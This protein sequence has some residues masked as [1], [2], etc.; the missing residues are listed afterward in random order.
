VFT[1][2]YT[3]PLDPNDPTQVNMERRYP[4]VK[5]RKLMSSGEPFAKVDLLL[6]GD[7]YTEKEME[8]FENDV[9]HFT[10]VLFDTEPFKT[11]KIDFNVWTI[12][13][14]SV[15]S[16]IDKPD[17][18]VW[19]STPL[20]T[21]YNTFGSARYVLTEE[22][23]ALRDICSAV[24]Y[25]AIYILVNDNRY[26]GGGIYN[27][28][29]TC[30]TVTDAKGREWQ[31]DYV[32]VHEF[33]HSFAALADEYYSSDVAYNDMY[34]AGVEPWEPNITRYYD[35]SSFKWQHL[36]DKDLPLPTPWGKEE[37]DSLESERRKLDRL[38]PDYY[39]KA[40]PLMEKAQS[41]LRNPVLKGKVGLFEGAGYNSTGM[42]RPSLDC[43]M[44]SLSL[45]PFDPV[46]SEAIERMI[47]YYVR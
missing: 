12:E 24:P 4:Q 21:M 37:Y 33:G 14:P 3:F 23:K 16:G 19:R 11:R 5:V 22:N 35:P 17:R 38:A 6:V 41:Y 34:P 20:G 2:L 10:S 29:A 27:L 15:E 8:R 43:R 18:N 28:Y 1:D 46:C 36:A 42:Y 32:F 45:V 9:K 47:D 40:G 7:G 44:F 13:L 30:Y 39:K 26:G 31:M 25:D